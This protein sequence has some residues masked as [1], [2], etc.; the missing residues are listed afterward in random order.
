MGRIGKVVML[1]VLA[2]T[3]SSAAPLSKIDKEYKKSEESG[4]L[5]DL[6]D[7]LGELDGTGDD[8]LYEI[9]EKVAKEIE[10]Y[11]NAE[12]NVALCDL[13]SFYGPKMASNEYYK[14]NDNLALKWLIAGEIRGLNCEIER[15]WEPEAL[16]IRVTKANK[17]SSLEYMVTAITVFVP[18]KEIKKHI[19][20]YYKAKEWLAVKKTLKKMPVVVK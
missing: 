19:P 4:K 11:A 2:A 6:Y 17:M 1:I 10:K 8:K 14:A 5:R 20:N 12:S 3:V 7:Q 13:A 15:K 16:G 18:S 9:A